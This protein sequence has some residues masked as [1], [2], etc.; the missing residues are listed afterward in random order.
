MTNRLHDLVTYK[1]IAA[2]K[3]RDYGTV[4][5]YA[6][7]EPDFPKPELI[8]GVTKFFKR[9]AVDAFFSRRGGRRASK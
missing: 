1:Q 2:E 9:T 4:R 5:I 3:D 6:I 8:I 7:T